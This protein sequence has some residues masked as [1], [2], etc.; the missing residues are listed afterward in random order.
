M[1]KSLQLSLDLT[2][3]WLGPHTLASNYKHAIQTYILKIGNNGG[4]L[5][6]C[7][8]KQF[9]VFKQY[10]TY[11]HTLFHPHE[12][13]KNTNNVIRTTLPN[14]SITRTQFLLLS[15]KILSLELWKCN[16]KTRP[17]NSK[18]NGPHIF[19]ENY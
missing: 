14:S 1:R 10:Y 7:F 8:E 3:H 11:F 9:S 16:P 6:M 15:L 2:S 13:L 12:F 4:Y 17:N 5:V 18:F 19:K